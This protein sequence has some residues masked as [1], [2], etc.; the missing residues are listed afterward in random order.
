MDTAGANTRGGCWEDRSSPRGPRRA[1]RELLPKSPRRPHV[2]SLRTCW[3]LG[4]P[5]K[6][7]PSCTSGK[8]WRPARSAVGQRCPSVHSHPVSTCHPGVVSCLPSCG[9][10]ARTGLPSNAS[11]PPPRPCSGPGTWPHGGGGVR[12]SPCPYG[13][14]IKRLPGWGG[15]PGEQLHRAQWVSRGGRE[16]FPRVGKALGGAPSYFSV[17]RCRAL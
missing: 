5:G 9:P 11:H 7:A 13:A 10:A 14:H 2:G 15:G 1:G 8:G 16:L 17:S 4:P 6:R 3:T 12:P